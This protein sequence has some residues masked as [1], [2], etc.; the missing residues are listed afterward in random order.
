VRRGGGVTSHYPSP[1]VAK[2]RG[3]REYKK[4]GVKFMNLRINNH[5][6]KAS[7]LQNNSKSL[8]NKALELQETLKNLRLSGFLI[9]IKIKN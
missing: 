9:Q 3:E 7:S 4:Y 2:A 8:L 1:L 5:S 6:P